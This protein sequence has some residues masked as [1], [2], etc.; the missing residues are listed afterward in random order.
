MMG[1]GATVALLVSLAAVGS[2]FGHAAEV[3][4]TKDV[5]VHENYT[6]NPERRQFVVPVAQQLFH[7]PV[8]GLHSCE[9]L[10]NGYDSC[11]AGMNSCECGLRSWE[12]AGCE[13]AKLCTN[14]T[15]STIKECCEG[16][17]T[18]PFEAGP[19][20]EGYMAKCA[21][22]YRLTKA[23]NPVHKYMSCAELEGWKPNRADARLHGLRALE[24]LRTQCND[25][26]TRAE[27]CN[28][29]QPSLQDRPGY[30]RYMMMCLDGVKEENPVQKVLGKSG[31]L[32]FVNKTHYYADTGKYWSNDAQGW[33]AD[34]SV[35]RPDT[36]GY[37][38]CPQKRS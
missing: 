37:G 32:C 28:S 22:N 16:R 25:T 30:N 11:S 33:Y 23:D 15:S 20:Y 8:V 2:N 3:P 13:R 34:P 7:E 12:R 35:P 19:Y 27:C 38:P 14:S 9:K 29:Y 26:A 5:P 21:P 1:K 6:P 4:A 31:G 36:A 18:I 17:D 24:K 10:E